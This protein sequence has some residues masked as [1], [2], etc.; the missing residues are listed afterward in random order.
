MFGDTVTICP[1][2]AETVPD[3]IGCPSN[4]A[5]G[6]KLSKNSRLVGIWEPRGELCCPV[7][8]HSW[9]PWVGWRVCMHGS[10]HS[11]SNCW[12]VLGSAVPL[13]PELGVGTRWRWG[14]GW[15]KSTAQALSALHWLT[16]PAPSQ[17][18]QPHLGYISLGWARP[19]LA[20][21]SHTLP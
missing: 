14:A 12:N 20:W 4:L 11:W 17:H 3:S 15:A 8:P 10:R 1:G 19:G 13:S 21:P 2:V 18:L 6:E 5:I 7:Q 16:A 9:E